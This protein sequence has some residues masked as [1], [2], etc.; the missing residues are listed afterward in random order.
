MHYHITAI[1][2]IVANATLCNQIDTIETLFNQA[3]TLLMQ[4]SY[5]DAIA[6]YH[7]ILKEQPD[8]EDAHLGLGLTYL[9]VQYPGEYNPALQ[10][11]HELLSMIDQQLPEDITPISTATHDINITLSSIL[12]HAKHSITIETSFGEFIDKMTTLKIKMN[13][14]EDEAKL[15]NIKKLLDN[16]QTLY[17]KYVEPSAQL[18]QLMQ[19]LLKVLET[20]WDLEEAMRNKECTQLF[21]QE[22]IDLV[23]TTYLTNDKRYNLKRSISELLGSNIM[24]E[25]SYNTN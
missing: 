6:L 16:A 14:I 15:H 23:R 7:T 4:S 12:Q 21:D 17:N 5:N 18:D 1:C 9:I 8:H 10:K 19:E 13:R 25:K 3:N 11:I 24:E 22:F 20:L 2:I